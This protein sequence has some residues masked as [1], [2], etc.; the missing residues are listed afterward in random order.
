MLMLVQYSL[1]RSLR[2]CLL[3]ICRLPSMKM[4]GQ[5]HYICFKSIVFLSSHLYFV[6]I[7]S[8]MAFDSCRDN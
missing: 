1:A 2:E 4:P 6:I 8:R 5:L 7:D 3:S